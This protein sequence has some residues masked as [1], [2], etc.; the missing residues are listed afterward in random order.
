ME[1]C[2]TFQKGVGG[3]FQMRASFLSG[4][5]AVFDKN[6]WIIGGMGVPPSPNPLHYGKRC[7]IC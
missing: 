5:N 4:G 3:V 2:F 1:G 6:L 7:N